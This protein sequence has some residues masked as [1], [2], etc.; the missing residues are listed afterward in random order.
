DREREGTT[1]ELA[2]AAAGQTHARA[3]ADVAGEAKT[4][5]S[6]PLQHPP[7]AERERD[8]CQGGEETAAGGGMADERQRDQKRPQPEQHTSFLADDA[9]PVT[10]LETVQNLDHDDREQDEHHKHG[11]IAATVKTLKYLG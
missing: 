1:L 8:N 4:E 3:H 10:Q 6:E 2:A 11:A 5:V 9:P 7:G